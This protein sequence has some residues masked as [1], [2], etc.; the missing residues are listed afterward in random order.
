M[1]STLFLALSLILATAVLLGL[2]YVQLPGRR[3]HELVVRSWIAPMTIAGYLLLW[4]GFIL[5]VVGL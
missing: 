4:V 2:S 5:Q 3:K 1:T